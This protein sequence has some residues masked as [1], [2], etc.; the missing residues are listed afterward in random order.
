VEAVTC[1]RDRSPDHFWIAEVRRQSRLLRT[2]R[3][4]SRRKPYRAPAG[5]ATA[6]GRRSRRLVRQPGVATLHSPPPEPGC[7]GRLSCGS[8]NRGRTGRRRAPG[9]GPIYHSLYDGA[10]AYGPGGTTSRR[11][12]TSQSA[13][14]N[15]AT[16]SPTSQ[17]GRPSTPPGQPPQPLRRSDGLGAEGRFELDRGVKLDEPAGPRVDDL[18][19]GGPVHHQVPLGQLQGSTLWRS[20]TMWSR[21]NNGLGSVSKPS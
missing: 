21:R 20:V 11:S 17:C 18:L 4:R 2:S 19:D 14:H 8:P 10:F 7:G 12:A 3:R 15:T 13:G 5:S 16:C 6:T 9:P 1:Y